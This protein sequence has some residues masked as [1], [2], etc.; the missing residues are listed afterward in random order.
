[1][2]TLADLQAA[3]ARIGTDVEALIA[4]ETPTD[5]QAEFDA[6]NATAATAEAALPA[7]EPA[8]E[9]AAE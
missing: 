9:P 6:L 3:V 1:M 7:P 2:A 5:L 8:D 4:A